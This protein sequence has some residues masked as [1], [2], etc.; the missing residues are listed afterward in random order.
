MTQIACYYQIALLLNTL[1]ETLPLC[2]AVG[3]IRSGEN[4]GCERGLLFKWIRAINHPT[5]TEVL[6]PI[7]KHMD[8]ILVPV[9]QAQS[10]YVQLLEKV[11]Q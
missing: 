1:R 4:V 10:V 6:T 11:P 8:D 3:R 5:R 7:E 2:D 9:E